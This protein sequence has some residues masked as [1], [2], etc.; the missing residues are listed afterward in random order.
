MHLR[1]LLGL[2]P[3]RS[4]AP[5]LSPHS[6]LSRENPCWRHFPSQGAASY[7]HTGLTPSTPAILHGG[8]WSKWS[9]GWLVSHD[10]G[11]TGRQT[12]L[13]VWTLIRCNILTG[14]QDLGYLRVRGGESYLWYPGNLTKLPKERG[15]VLLSPCCPAQA[16]G[17][18]L[19]PV[20]S[21]SGI[22]FR[23]G[24]RVFFFSP[25][26]GSLMTGSRGNTYVA[27][28]EREISSSLAVMR[29]LATTF[30]GALMAASPVFCSRY[31][32]CDISSLKVHLLKAVW[33]VH[34]YVLAPS[35]LGTSRHTQ[36]VHDNCEVPSPPHKVP[37]R[38][39]EAPL[40]LTS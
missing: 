2:S 19:T 18:E 21:G 4:S 10:H 8:A 5:S 27:T 31:Y 34:C 12:A 29:W 7:G 25:T 26:T 15:E 20:L 13:A 6:A 23:Q 32:H 33:L 40:H 16:P 28:V 37:G 39:V 24:N 14:P 17:P 22:C 3:T 35:I 11:H 9:R 1:H 38:S 36:T 30:Q